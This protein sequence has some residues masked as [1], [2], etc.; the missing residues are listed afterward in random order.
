MSAQFAH[1]CVTALKKSQK[2]RLAT[3]HA[4]LGADCCYR[5]CSAL[6]VCVGHDCESCKTAEPIE[7]LFRTQPRRGPRNDVTGSYTLGGHV[8]DTRTRLRTRL[9]ALFPRLPGWAG[10]RKV[11]PIRILLKLETVTGSGISWPICKSALCSR[12]ITTPVPHYS[13]FTGRMPFLPPNQ[14]CQSTEGRCTR[15]SLDKKRV[16][17]SCPPDA[18]NSTQQGRYTAAATIMQ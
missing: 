13:V 4:V 16:Q 8:P 10:T 17:T 9:T 3:R 11:K 18:T 6:C 5:R 14:Q 12:Q 1:N 2:N 15:H 7:M